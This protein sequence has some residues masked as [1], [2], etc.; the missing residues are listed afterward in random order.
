VIKGQIGWGTEAELVGVSYHEEWRRAYIDYRS[1]YATLKLKI[2]PAD[3]CLPVRFLTTQ[4]TEE[5]DQSG[6]QV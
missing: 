6:S 1:V 5:A 4:T 3:L 2:W